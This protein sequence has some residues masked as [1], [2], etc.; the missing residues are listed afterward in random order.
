MQQTHQQDGNHKPSTSQFSGVPLPVPSLP[1]DP[2]RRFARKAAEI[3][4][5]AKAFVVAVAILSVW[6]V[7]GP[8]FGF[9]NTWQLMIN[10]T[11]TI[12]T[13]LMV[14][15]IQN[16]QN[17]DSRQLNLKLDELIRSSRSAKD[18][19]IDL[20][21]MSDQE[22]AAMEE[23]FIRESHKRKYHHHI[24]QKTQSNTPIANENSN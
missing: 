1:N 12:V 8:F 5:S 22:L 16:T 10:T 7:S 3:V 11:T 23:K 14:F 9:S 24:Q 21:S 17:R 13:F 2:F 4:G 20:E 15:I 19:Y 6:A 18:K